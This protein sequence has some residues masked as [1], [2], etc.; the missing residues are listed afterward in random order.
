MP[1]PAVAAHFEAEIICAVVV[2]ASGDPLQRRKWNVDETLA[3]TAKD[4]FWKWLVLSL[5]SSQQPYREGSPTWRLENSV[6]PFPLPMQEFGPLSEIQI[7]E[8]LKQFR[9]HDRITKQLLAN[10]RWLFAPGDGWNRTVQPMLKGLLEQRNASPNAAHKELERQT[11]NTLVEKLHGVGPKQARNLLQSLGLTRYEIPLDSRVVGWLRDCLGWN[12]IIEALVW[13]DYYEDLLDR[14]QASCEAASVLP[15]IFDAAVFDSMG[16]TETVKATAT[17]C[18]G[19]LNKNG[20]VVVR[21]TRAPGTDK[22]QYVNQLACSHCGH[23]YG[24]NGSDIHERLCPRC[25]GGA[26]GLE[27]SNAK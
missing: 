21:K 24:S 11:A 5:L 22:N 18:T 25:Q 4:D 3:P 20:Q 7:S 23:V 1:D 27:Y 2:G 12:I 19:Y 14:V 8:R 17:T 16:R 15:T 26:P 13:K 10:Y 6:D 9:F